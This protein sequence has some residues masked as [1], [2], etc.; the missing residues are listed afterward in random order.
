MRRRATEAVPLTADYPGTSKNPMCVEGARLLPERPRR[1]DEPLV[2]EPD[3][4]DLRQH[5]RHKDFDPGRR[6]SPTAASST[7][8]AR[9][10]GCSISKSGDRH[11]G[12]D[13]L[14]SDFEQLRE[15]WVKKP[16]QYL[17]AG[18]P[19]AGWRGWCSRRAGE[20]FVAPAK[21][22]RL[23]RV[24]R[25]PGVRFRDARYSADGKSIAGDDDARAAR[26]EFWRYPANGVGAAR[27]AHQGRQG[28]ALGRRAFA[29]RQV[30]GAHE[31][32]PA[33]VAV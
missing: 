21:P 27:A 22:G 5:T 24:A 4:K 8:S 13:P 16:A 32:G 6:R 20:V 28:A 10:S 17:T 18:A 7:S 3:G 12:P 30:D 19:V 31:Q 29:R 25:K 2:D 23:V 26:L 11:G 9:I 33:T 14:V 1:R 15:R